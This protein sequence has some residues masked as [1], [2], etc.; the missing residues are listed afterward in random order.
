MEGVLLLIF[1]ILKV[2]LQTLC[3]LSMQLQMSLF[4]RTQETKVMPVKY[5]IQLTILSAQVMF[6]IMMQLMLFGEFDSKTVHVGSKNQVSIHGIYFAI[7]ARIILV[8]S[9]FDICA[10]GII[11]S[12]LL[13]DMHCV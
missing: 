5:G 13:F 11:I 9:V 1:C 6:L 10:G 3:I 8:T 7:Y 12:T 4:C 2:L